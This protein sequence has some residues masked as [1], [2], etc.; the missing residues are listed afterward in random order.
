MIKIALS[1]DDGR[2]DQY[3]TFKEILNKKHMPATLYVTTGYVLKNIDVADCP[4]GHTPMTIEQLKEI[5]TINNFEVSG[6]GRKHNNDLENFI[7][8]INDLRQYL[9]YDNNDTFGIASPQ[10]RLNLNDVPAM[11]EILKKNKINYIRT[12]D[13]FYHN[14]FI[15]KVI[16]RLNRVIKSSLLFNYVYK[17][18]AVEVSDKDVLH[19]VIVTKY[20][21]L[22][23]LKKFIKF[24]IKSNKS[25]VLMFHSILKSNEDFYNDTY[26]W[27]YNKFNVFCDYLK[28][29]EINGII[30]MVKVSE[31]IK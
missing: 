3:R 20:D 14:A 13:R 30:E 31:F 23:M 12:G 16:R 19:S 29:L 11:K 10:C 4:S 6:H 24:A 8:G 21:T 5:K 1:F 7:D 18:S 25:Y 28:K 26:S 2:S 22:R 27:D 15:K 17:D 9:D